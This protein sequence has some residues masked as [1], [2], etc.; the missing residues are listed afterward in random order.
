MAFI[1]LVG[2]LLAVGACAENPIRASSSH[3]V[4]P[5]RVADVL[6]GTELRQAFVVRHIIYRL[7]FTYQTKPRYLNFM[8]LNKYKWNGVQR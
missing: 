5:K 7:L 2:V 1:T 8:N 6:A 3:V 4:D